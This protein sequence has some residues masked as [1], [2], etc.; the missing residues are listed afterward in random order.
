MTGN[1]DGSHNCVANTF[2]NLLHFGVTV[3]RNTD[4]YWVGDAGP[5][6]SYIPAGGEL[7][8]YVQRNA[9]RDNPYQIN[10]AQR[11]NIRMERNEATS[12]PN[13]PNS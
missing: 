5:G 11:N 8:P 6:A 1:E 4:L 10:I 13:Q 3:P 9:T 7:S 12:R 2:A